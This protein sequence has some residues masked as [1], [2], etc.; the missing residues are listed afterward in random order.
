MKKIVIVGAGPHS[1]VI[2]DLLEQ[3]GQ[4]EIVGLTD[5][6]EGEVL[7]YPILGTDEVLAELH[8]NNVEYAFPAVGDNRIR[9]KLFQK[10]EKI[11][12]EIPNAISPHALI[13]RYA[14]FQRGIAVMPGAVINAQARIGDGVIVN[15][16]ASVDHDCEIGEF[17]HIAP[18]CSISGST[19]IGGGCFLGTGTSVIDRIHIGENTSVGAGAVVVRDL[20]DNCKA[21]GVPAHVI[22]DQHSLE[23]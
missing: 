9:R 23:K 17:S 6:I 19:K 13:S 4:Y 11:G 3:M 2:I 20:P 12:L 15:T 1:E 14:Q 7:G 21:V 5:E 8:R 10:L 16:K 18:G 22:A